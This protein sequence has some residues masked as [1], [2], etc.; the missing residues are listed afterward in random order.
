MEWSFIYFQ[1]P[2]LLFLYLKKKNQQKNVQL[3]TQMIEILQAFTSVLQLTKS[4]NLLLSLLL[5]R[6]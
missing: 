1:S 5:K 4:M 3:H 2:V 6:F